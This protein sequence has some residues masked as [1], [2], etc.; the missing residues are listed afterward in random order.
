MTQKKLLLVVG[1]VVLAITAAVAFAGPPPYEKAAD[2]LTANCV[3]ITASSV[4]LTLPRSGDWY[5]VIAEGNTAYLLGGSNP[6]ATTS[7][8][9]FSIHAPD[10]APLLMRLVGPKVAV[11]GTSAAGKICFIRQIGTGPA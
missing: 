5:Y 9:G 6:T 4:Q 2:S 1:L 11:I 7:I 8:G 3:A 10:S